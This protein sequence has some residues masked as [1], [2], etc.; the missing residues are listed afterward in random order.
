MM[1]NAHERLIFYD[2]QF[3]IFF[4]DTHVSHWNV[5]IPIDNCVNYQQVFKIV[6]YIFQKIHT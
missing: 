5:S 6:N 4:I 3:S 2:I 1:L